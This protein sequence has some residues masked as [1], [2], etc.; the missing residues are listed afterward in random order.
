[1][2]LMLTEDPEKMLSSFHKEAEAGCL[3][4][5]TVWGKKELNKFHVELA[6]SVK[7]LGFPAANIR[8]NFHLYQKVGE[9]AEKAGWEVLVS[10]DQVAS[11]PFLCVEAIEVNAEFATSNMKG[12]SEDQKKAVK[13]HYLA[14]MKEAFA[15][16]EGLVMPAELYVLLKK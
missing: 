4:G 1:M 11:L 9:L 3:L 2:V 8:S 12:L 13:E 10:W 15:R 14:K 6:N 16:K 5:V 7:E